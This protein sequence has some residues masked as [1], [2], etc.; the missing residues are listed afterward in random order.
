LKVYLE[1]QCLKAQ[2][3]IRIDKLWDGESSLGI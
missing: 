3:S 2:Q 1:R